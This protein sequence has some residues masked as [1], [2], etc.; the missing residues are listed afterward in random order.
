MVTGSA[1]VELARTSE[2]PC[3]SVIAIPNNTPDFVAGSRSSGSYTRDSSAAS[4]SAASPGLM[5]S[6]GTTACVIDSGQPCPASICETS[7]NPAARSTFAPTPGSAHAE[8][9]RPRETENS[10]IR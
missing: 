2:P 1:I 7:M 4:H 10:M 9:W 5:R 3:F 8:V 6:D